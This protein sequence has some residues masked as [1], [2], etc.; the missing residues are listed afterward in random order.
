MPFHWNILSV[1]PIQ[2]LPIIPY[3]ILMWSIQEAFSSILKQNILVI[4]LNSY[5]SDINQSLLLI[6]S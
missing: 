4:L 3:I 1:L 2:M 6:I 5:G